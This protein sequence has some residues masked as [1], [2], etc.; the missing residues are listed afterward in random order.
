MR[1]SE[2]RHHSKKYY[3]FHRDHS[4]DT[5]ECFR[6][7]DKIE[8]LIRCGVFNQFVQNQ[9]DERRSVKNVAPPEGPNDNMPIA[10]TINTIRRGPTERSSAGESTER[11]TPSKHQCTYE[12]ILFS[13]E[14]LK[15]VE[16]LHDDAVVISMV[17]NKFD[18]KH[19]LVDNESSANICIIMPSKK[20]NDRQ[21]APVNAPLVGFT[22]NSVSVEGETHLLVTVGLAPREST[23]RMNFLVV[24]LPSVYNVI[25]GRPGLNAFQ[26]VVSMYHL[27]MWFPTEQGVGEA[28]RDQMIAK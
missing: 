25:L 27:L 4:H 16:T 8:A 12:V 26:A 28:R 23:V 3:R 14:D 9:H 5:N 2:L 20:W 7:R 21:P 19:V 17:M 1:E 18:V 11:R 10:G 6:L 15:G 22:G 13:N 24:R